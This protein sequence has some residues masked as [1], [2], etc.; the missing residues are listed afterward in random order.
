MS[1]KE[2][3]LRAEK[4]LAH[5]PSDSEKEAVRRS[6]D[7]A[8]E[9]TYGVL[10]DPDIALSKEERALQACQ[11]A[12]SQDCVATNLRKG[13]K[14]CQKTRSLPDPM[15]IPPLPRLLPVRSSLPH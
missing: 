8:I 11:S 6:S 1:D 7:A 9:T 14:A 5:S 10:K 2:V 3:D 15:A 13:E 4:E 12:S